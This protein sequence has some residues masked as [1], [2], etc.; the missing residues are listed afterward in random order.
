[1]AGAVSHAPRTQLAE[2]RG[3]GVPLFFRTKRG[4]FPVSFSMLFL[5][6]VNKNNVKNTLN[7]GSTVVWPVKTPHFPFDIRTPAA[8]RE[9]TALPWR[10][11]CWRSG[12][13]DGR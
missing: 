3:R 11:T 10:P 12:P 2:I 13:E 7:F 4:E 1:M 9:A 5:T 8:S 6:V